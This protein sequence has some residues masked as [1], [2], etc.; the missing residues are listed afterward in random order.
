[1][2]KNVVAQVSGGSKKVLDDV[3]NVGDVKEELDA[4]GYTALLNGEPASD[5]TQLRD[6][7]FVV[8]AKAAKGGR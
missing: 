4:D 5:E 6:A 1:M 8:L 2:A 3:E 7:D